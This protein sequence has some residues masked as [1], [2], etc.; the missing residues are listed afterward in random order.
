MQFLR[1]T[2]GLSLLIVLSAFTALHLSYWKTTEA[3][4]ITFS[5]K[6]VKGSFKGLKASIVFD[7]NNLSA[8]KI[9]ASIDA[10]TVNTGIKLKNKHARGKKALNAA[11][12][13]IIRF[14]STQ[15]VKTAT[16]YEAIGTLTLRDVTKEIKLPFTFE[17]HVFKGHFSLV[18]HEYH[19]T[20]HGVP[21][22]V[23]VE[24]TVPVEQ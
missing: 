5:G 13:P 9:S 15:I 1:S 3:Y 17:G 19:V 10:S 4:S 21:E 6:H 24:L 20:R 16:G 2:I 7:E 11:E 12:F 23:T 22:T 18:P 14:E 8:A